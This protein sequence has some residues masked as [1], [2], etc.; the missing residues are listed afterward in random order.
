MSEVSAKLY[1][2]QKRNEFSSVITYVKP[3]GLEMK[4][5]IHWKTTLFR[6]QKVS[7]LSSG[8]MMKKCR[9]SNKAWWALQTTHTAGSVEFRRAAVNL[10]TTKYKW[11]QYFSL[12]FTIIILCCHGC[13]SAESRCRSHCWQIV[14]SCCIR[15]KCIEV[16]RSALF[17]IFD[18]EIHLSSFNLQTGSRLHPIKT[19]GKMERR[20]KSFCQLYYVVFTK[21]VWKK[22]FQHCT[23]A[24]KWQ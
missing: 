18:Y 11:S 24:L 10:I 20:K 8:F 4:P 14:E 16:C 22:G 17:N 1:Y 7:F 13:C 2:C 15:G 3:K 5:G 6:C 23:T 9:I 19:R 12:D 21:L